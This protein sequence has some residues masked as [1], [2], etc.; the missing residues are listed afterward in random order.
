M[1]SFCLVCLVFSKHHLLP[2]F[3]ASTGVVVGDLP[4]AR[5]TCPT[6]GATKISRTYI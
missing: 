1:F 2:S 6:A 3:I 5:N 4:P